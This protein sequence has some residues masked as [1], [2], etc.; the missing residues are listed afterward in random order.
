MSRESFEELRNASAEGGGSYLLHLGGERLVERALFDVDA[1]A[2]VA[3]YEA[4]ARG[5][6][7]VD[8]ASQ[9]RASG[10]G[11]QAGDRGAA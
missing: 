10:L 9:H 4:I 5:E 7:P 11:E 3:F 6:V 8:L 2:A 1:G